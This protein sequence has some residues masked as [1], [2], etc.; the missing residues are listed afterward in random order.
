MRHNLLDLPAFAGD[1]FTPLANANSSGATMPTDTAVPMTAAQAARLFALL[2][3]ETRL[4]LL[5]RLAEGS[6]LPVTA[7]AEAFG[8]SQPTLSHHLQR[9]RL[10]GVV[11]CRREGRNTFYALTPGPARDLL[12]DNVRP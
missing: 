10:A 12:L 4:R 6:D 3:D 7:L 5:M 9:L 1:N 11:T 8:M 2:G